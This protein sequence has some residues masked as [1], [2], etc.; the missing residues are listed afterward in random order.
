MNA[1]V[2]LSLR[3][4][5][6]AAEALVRNKGMDSRAA[7]QQIAI[8]TLRTHYRI[9]FDGNGYSEEWVQEAARRGLLNYRTTVQAYSNIK[10]HDLYVRS[11]VFTEREVDSRVNVALETY[12]KNKRIEVKAMLNLI[13][14]YI[15]PSGQKTIER[16]KTTLDAAG[17]SA[18]ACDHVKLRMA[19]VIG[20]VD[21]IIKGRDELSAELD[22][23]DD[24]LLKEAQHIDSTINPSME[25]VRK[26][27]DDLESYVASEDWTLP[28]YHEMLFL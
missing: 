14:R 2:C 11:G 5:N 7:I 28:T 1:S 9:I 4:M 23:H 16:L 15:F 18:V 19:K 27:C 24:D 12:I 10:L 26:A 8:E 3:A 13:D 22:V 20:L 6:D 17:P 21:E 25:T